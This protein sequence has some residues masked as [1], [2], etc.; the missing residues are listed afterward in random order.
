MNNLDKLRRTRKKD[1][2]ISIRISS[3]LS[4]WIDKYK[5]SKTRI[6]ENACEDLGFPGNPNKR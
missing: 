1:I 4:A 6:F 2:A 3:E 5:L